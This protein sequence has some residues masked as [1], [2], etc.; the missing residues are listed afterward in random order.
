MSAVF[1]AITII[2]MNLKA[3][4]QVLL[5]AT[6]RPFPARPEP[7]HAHTHRTHRPLPWQSGGCLEMSQS[8]TPFD[9]GL[10]TPGTLGAL[11]PPSCNPPPVTLS[12]QIHLSLYTVSHSNL[13]K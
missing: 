13:I 6:P 12:S 10:P 11:Y 5:L 2:K 1:T 7:A 9:A 4:L 3:E 8:L